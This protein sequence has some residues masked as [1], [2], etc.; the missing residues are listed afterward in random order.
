MRVTCGFNQRLTHRLFLSF[1]HSVSLSRQ[2]V[3]IHVLPS[4]AEVSG[5]SAHPV[6]TDPPGLSEADWENNEKGLREACHHPHG[7]QLHELSA[8]LL[9][10]SL[11][12]V[13][14]DMDRMLPGYLCVCRFTGALWLLRFKCL[15]TFC[16][17]CL[18]LKGNVLFFIV[19]KYYLSFF[20]RYLFLKDSCYYHEFN[21]LSQRVG[22]EKGTFPSPQIWDPVSVWKIIIIWYSLEP[23]YATCSLTLI[24]K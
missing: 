11:A 20:K 10:V 16:L 21:I 24:K 5:D 15:V 3:P 12:S 6:W 14:E 17:S 23:C 2:S 13:T 7:P 9:W 19:F 18:S 22:R 8:P 4:P 1:C